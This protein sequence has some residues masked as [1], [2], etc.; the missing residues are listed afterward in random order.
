MTEERSISESFSSFSIELVGSEESEEEI[1]SDILDDT[2]IIDVE[3]N[4][5]RNDNNDLAEITS[6][7]TISSPI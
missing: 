4:H 7:M 3:D 2:P 5:Q 6:R 1:Y